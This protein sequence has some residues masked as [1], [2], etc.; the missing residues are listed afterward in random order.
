MDPHTAVMLFGVGAA[1]IGLWI[2]A[3]FP[4]R[5]PQSVRSA[6]MMLIAVIVLQSPFLRLVHPVAVEH[7]VASALLLIVLPTLTTLFWSAAR[8]VR[9]LVLLMAPYRR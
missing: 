4:D 6:G 1:A 2:V 7:G 5:G 9:S 8:L 3:R